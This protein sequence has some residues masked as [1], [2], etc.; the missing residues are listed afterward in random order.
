MEARGFG[1]PGATRMPRPPWTALDRLAVLCALIVV[2][3]AAWL[4]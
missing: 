2:G 3:G 1:R 4:R